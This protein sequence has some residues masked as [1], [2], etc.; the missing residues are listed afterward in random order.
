MLELLMYSQI[1]CEGAA[2]IADR[3][4]ANENM[5]IPVREELIQVVKEATPNCPWDA[6]D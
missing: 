3:I 5:P 1:S 2:G 6:N 4:K